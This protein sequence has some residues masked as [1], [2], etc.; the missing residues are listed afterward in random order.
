MNGLADKTFTI[1]QATR[2]RLVGWIIFNDLTVQDTIENFIKGEMVRLCFLI[3][4]VSD[5]NAMVTD[6]I[7]DRLNIHKMT[8]PNRMISSL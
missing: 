5:M 6:S 1:D 8:L 2:I 3:G 4:V 7:N